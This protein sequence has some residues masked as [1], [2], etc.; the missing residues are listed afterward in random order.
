MS[1]LCLGAAEPM[2]HKYLKAFAPML[3]GAAV[4]ASSSVSRAGDPAAAEALFQT[5]KSLMDKKKYDEACPKLEASYNLDPAVGTKLNLADCLEK[6]GK[7]AQAWVSW[8][9]AR[10][11]AKKE[12]DQP[13]AD[14]AARR[15]KELD[16]RVPRLSVTVKGSTDG[17][18]VFRDEVALVPASFGVPLPVDPG[19]H[20]VTLRRG[21]TILKTEDVESKEKAKDEVE[22]DA[23]DVPPAPIAPVPTADAKDSKHKTVMVRRSKGMIVGGS[24][25]VAGGSLL[26]LG[27]LATLAVSNATGA[28][29]II[30]LL[31][32]GGTAG[33]IAMIVSGSKKVPKQT[34]TSVFIGPTSVMVQGTF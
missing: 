27:G 16:P 14:L 10:D 19:K 20:V 6:Q 34:D 9:D 8:G 31:G 13:R 2:R 24:F 7:L 22:L 15:Q 18:V 23:T 29:A 33:G 32:A 25:V 12:N 5:G 28:G 3:I 26:F 4:L 21:E 11:Q 17:L 30:T 1:I